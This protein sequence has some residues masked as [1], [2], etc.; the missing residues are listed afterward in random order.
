RFRTFRIGSSSSTTRTVTGPVAGWA[1]APTSGAAGV[2]I[3]STG[4]P[5]SGKWLQQFVFART[6]AEGGSFPL[7]ELHLDWLGDH[8]A[9][10]PPVQQHLDRLAPTGPIVH[11][12]LV[13]IH[14]H[15]P[16]GALLAQPAVEARR[17]GKGGPTVAQGVLHTGTDVLGNPGDELGSQVSP[18]YVAAQ[19]QRKAG[20]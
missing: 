1:G 12:P 15:E 3:G 5:G 8:P 16:V 17:V 20:V 6:R 13:H 2:A 18:D 4:G 14:S 19:R 11:R 7:D 10:V 9:R